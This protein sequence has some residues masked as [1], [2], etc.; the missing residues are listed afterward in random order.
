MRKVVIGAT[1]TGTRTGTTL[2]LTGKSLWPV[3]SA[4]GRRA[5]ITT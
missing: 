5:L 2:A 4:D 1:A 3:L